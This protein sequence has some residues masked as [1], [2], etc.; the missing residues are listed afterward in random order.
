MG[1]FLRFRRDLLQILEMPDT[2]DRIH[3]CE[4]LHRDL[5]PSIQKADRQ[6][7]PERPPVRK[8]PL[9]RSFRHSLLQHARCATVKPIVRQTKFPPGIGYG[10]LHF[11]W[12]DLARIQIPIL[13]DNAENIHIHGG[14]G[15]QSQ[16]AESRG[17]AA[18]HF[19]I[20]SSVK[21]KH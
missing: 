17:A 5:I 2:I 6:T 21:G 19:D 11:R 1:D 14:T 16:H 10:T 15:E 4:E 18:Q 9:Q 8:R 12:K 13:H 20:G 7:W 3:R